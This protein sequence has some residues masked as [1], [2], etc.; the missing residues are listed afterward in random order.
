MTALNLF[1]TRFDQVLTFAEKRAHELKYI[2]LDTPGQIEV[3]TWS[4]SGTI[5]CDSLAAAFP[6]VVVY[7]MDTPRSANPITFMSNMTYAC[8]IMYKTKLPFIVAFNKTDVMSHD[9]AVN[10][11]DDFDAFQSALKNDDSYM[12]TLTRSMS[13]VMDEFYQNLRCVGVSAVTGAGMD[14]FFEAVADATKEY[15]EE[16]KPF[17]EK[18]AAENKRQKEEQQH[19]NRAALKKDLAK[20]K[21]QPVVLKATS[22]ED[23]I[24]SGVNIVDDYQDE[25]E[26]EADKNEF[27]DFMKK[28]KLTQSESMCK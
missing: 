17:L 13:L 3:F 5:I 9:F 24:G 19:K 10:W 11:M 23:D 27:E 8:S 4:A 14:K 12:S 7:V 22:P 26:E 20:S 15:N 16:Y 28:M 25:E 1:A 21:G 2:F 18:K 6:T